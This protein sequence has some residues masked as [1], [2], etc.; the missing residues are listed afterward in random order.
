MTDEDTNAQPERE[1]DDE[2]ADEARR[3]AL[4]RL[5]IFGACTAPAMMLLMSGRSGKARRTSI[6]AD[7][8]TT[9]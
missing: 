7:S 8:G 5:G 9:V 3:E 4:K 2:I 6:S 1:P